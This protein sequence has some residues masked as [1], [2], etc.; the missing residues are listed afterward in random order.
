MWTQADDLQITDALLNWINKW[1]ASTK[2]IS[3][4][5]F[6]SLTKMTSRLF[7]DSHLADCTWTRVLPGSKW[8]DRTD[9][10]CF[11]I[12]HMTLTR[13]YT[14]IYRCNPF[15]HAARTRFLHS[16]SSN[17]CLYTTVS[18]YLRRLSE[19]AL[20]WISVVPTVMLPVNVK[21][22]EATWPPALSLPTLCR[23]NS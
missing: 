13:L 17:L 9:T 7:A 21:D 14:R 1:P 20:R 8:P 22:G 11:E 10:F 5:S 12:Q 6:L 3:H 23:Y 15:S 2:Q 19:K 18:Q 4:M 16:I